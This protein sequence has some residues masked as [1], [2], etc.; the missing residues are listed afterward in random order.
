[1][2]CSDAQ[3]NSGRTVRLSPTLLPVLERPNADPQQCG[4][5]LLGEA[6]CVADGD[7]IG[8]VHLGN[9][10]CSARATHDGA[11]VVQPKPDFS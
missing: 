3:E 4:K 2:A 11:V 10:N 6:I 7:D 5:P 1:M 9:A 8:L